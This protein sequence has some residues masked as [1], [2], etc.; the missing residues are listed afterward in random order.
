MEICKFCEA[1]KGN[2]QCEE[3]SRSWATD[4][5]LE[6]QG[7]YMTEYSVAIVKR[8]WYQK[9]GKKSAG[10]TDDASAGHAAGA[11]AATGR[12]NGGG[13]RY[14]HARRDDVNGGKVYIQL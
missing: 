9:K 5:E 12:G 2:R 3:I 1:M 4:D 14:A 13:S 11:S 10:R 6:Q 7:K 8:S